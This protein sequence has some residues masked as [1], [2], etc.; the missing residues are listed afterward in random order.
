L[1]SL[2]LPR[3]I[4]HFLNFLNSFFSSVLYLFGSM[5]QAWDATMATGVDWKSITYPACL[6][7]TTDYRPDERT[8][9][10]DY[11]ISQYNLTPEE[12]TAMDSNSRSP[13]RA[14]LSTREV[15]L[16]LISQRLAQNFQRIVAPKV[17]M[18]FWTSVVVPLTLALLNLLKG[19]V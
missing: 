16:E 10:N 18:S 19:K 2:V 6:P 14:P 8:L 7:I 5:W 1:F 15:F 9:H 13:T 3:L 17:W 4:P 12:F 11:V